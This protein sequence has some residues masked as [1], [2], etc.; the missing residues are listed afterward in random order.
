M[1]EG[2]ERF[3]KAIDIIG[4]INIELK[5]FQHSAEITFE[6]QKDE[7]NSRVMRSEFEAGLNSLKEY[8]EKKMVS[9]NEEQQSQIKALSK[10]TE[11]RL[12]QFELNMK[13]LEKETVW[14]IK[15]YENL[16][17]ERP[18]MHFVKQ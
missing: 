3:M 6:K 11:K 2:M 8:L 13:K 1:W 9:D 14:K 15:D 18:T 12:D 16:L 5:E 7:I 17:A 10:R 4:K